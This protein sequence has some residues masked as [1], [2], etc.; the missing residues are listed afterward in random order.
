MLLGVCS[1]IGGCGSLLNIKVSEWFRKGLEIDATTIKCSGP[2][3]EDCQE[4][5]LLIQHRGL[6]GLSSPL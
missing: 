6:V 4:R 2:E 3:C 5:H 1:G